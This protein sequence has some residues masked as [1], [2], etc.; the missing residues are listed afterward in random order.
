M[1][2]K[3]TDSRFPGS[4]SISMASLIEPNLGN[5]CDLYLNDEE[6]RTNELD[7]VEVGLEPDTITISDDES[8][9][10]ASTSTIAQSHGEEIIA[11]RSSV[12]RQKKRLAQP[13]KQLPSKR[14][15]I[16]EP[17]YV[18]ERDVPYWEVER[19]I[20]KR[21]VKNEPEYLVKWT[22]FPMVESTWEPMCSFHPITMDCIWDYEYYLEDI[23]MSRSRNSLR[24]VPK[25]P[26]LDKTLSIILRPL[27][28]TSG[29]I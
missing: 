27:Q 14:I 1:R 4:A 15:K 26:L 20:G 2:M 18:D 11:S 5:I 29:E 23:Q 17:I 19:V 3:L 28:E 13:C 22:G 7:I 8:S 16:E 25:H 9:P 21:M 10:N 24:T 6:S 12:I